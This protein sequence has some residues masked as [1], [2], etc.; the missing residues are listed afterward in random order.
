MFV[1]WSR[2]WKFLFNFRF[3]CHTFILVVQMRMFV[4][5][6]FS[7][8]VWTPGHPLSLEYL[9]L[10]CYPKFNQS[11]FKNICHLFYFGIKVWN[12][13]IVVH[14]CWDMIIYVLL[15]R[16]MSSSIVTHVTLRKFHWGK[17][18]FYLN[19]CEELLNHY[20]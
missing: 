1:I 8:L 2:I 11:L 20:L 5:I 15:W 10:Y 12:W 6:F 14:T 17:D 7:V 3:T 4:R 18:F 19:F 13:N 16:Y 9:P